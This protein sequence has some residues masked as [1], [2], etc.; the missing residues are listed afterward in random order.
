MPSSAF[1]LGH[2]LSVVVAVALAIVLLAPANTFAAANQHTISVT[3]PVGRHEIAKTAEGHEVSVEGFG[4]LLVPGKPN[5]PSRIFAV[6]IPPGA[7]LAG[8]TYDAGD[9]AVLPGVYKVPPA[10]LPRVIGE[11]NPLIYAERKRAYDQSYK[12]VYGNDAAYPE[13]PVEFV[14]TAGYR[15]YNLVDVRVTPFAYRPLSGRLT[16]YPQVTVHVS[17]RLPAQPAAPIMGGTVRTERIAREIVLN[18]DEARNWY[19]GAKSRARG[20]HDFVIITLESLTYAVSPLVDWETYKGRTVEVVTTTWIDANYDGYDLAEKMRNFLRDKYPSEQWG[21]EDV[22][23]VGDPEDVPMRRTAQD[24]GYG[25]PETDYYYAELSLPDDESW[26]ADGDHQWGE[27]EDPIDFYAEVN[28]G[29]IPWTDWST[30]RSICQKS[31]AYEQSTDLS[32]KQNILLLGAYFWETTDSA[33]LMELKAD[34]PWMSDWT[35]TRL[36]EKNEDYWSSYDCDYALL[37]SNVRSVWRP[38]KYAFVNWGGH[39]TSTSAHI[40]GLSSPGFAGPAFIEANDCP[41]LNDDYPAI[42]FANACSN[43]DT[44]GYES[45]GQEMMKSGAVGFLGAT[46][47]AY[48]RYN[49]DDPYDGCSSSFDY[50]FTTFVTPGDITQGQAH[51]AALRHMYDHGLWAYTKYEIFEWGALWG[52]PDLGM[53]NWYMTMAFPD[54]VPE[55]LSPGEAVDITVQIDEGEESYVPGSGTLHYRYDGGAF[56][57][58]ALVPLGGELHQATLPVVS[59]GD[60]PEFYFSAEGTESGIVYQPTAAPAETFTA[61]VGEWVTFYTENLDTDPGWYAEPLW[62][63]GQP[64]G[65]GGDY[66][67]PDPTSGYTGDNV[68]GYNLDG[69]YERDLPAKHLVSNPIDCTGRGGVHLRFWRWLGIGDP[70][71]CARAYVWASNDA[72]NWSMIWE[73]TGEVV[74]FRWTE[75]DLDISAVAD[76]QPTVYLAWTMGPTHEWAQQ[77]CGWNIDDIRLVAF[78]CNPPAGDGDFE[79]DGDVDLADFVAF[80]RCFGTT[81]VSPPCRPGDLNGD[82]AIDLED[83]TLFA[84]ELDASGPR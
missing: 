81:P 46:E 70:D 66:G 78:E 63:F 76:D 64:T 47:V 13:N 6:A 34:Q 35:V 5:L 28:V 9:G 32:F 74:D 43:S 55:L 57:T 65:G 67:A 11:E 30:V 37:H 33:V 18:Y 31:A 7:E 73:N 79:P 54:G 12:S 16:Y 41:W 23:L 69:D 3:I 14:R 72:S 19:A 53:G 36:Y 39:G 84:A 17:Y 56:Q 29:R 52:N 68:Y 62:A 49:W 59:C 40:Y 2:R 77:Y 22:L 1:G 83:F 51:Q 48:G 42:V 20:L 82:D 38:G 80:Q 26:D 4:R 44:D 8:V 15:E 75:I 61:P 50:F 71:W 24:T 58:S 21:I 60:T 25:Q 10:P 45:I 27:Y